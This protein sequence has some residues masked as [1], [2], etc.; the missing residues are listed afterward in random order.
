MRVAS[1]PET[2]IPRACRRRYQR[3]LNVTGA[4]SLSSEAKLS[5]Q[6]AQLVLGA[7]G[8]ESRLGL[9]YA[10]PGFELRGAH[11]PS[12]GAHLPYIA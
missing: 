3:N 2:D 9:T 11:R 5:A 6:S 7:S 10:R 1:P 12:S 4:G 8:L